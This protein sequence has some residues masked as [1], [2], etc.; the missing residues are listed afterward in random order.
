MPM[1]TS[2]LA[3]LGAFRTELHACFPRRADALFEL[4]DALLCAE[5]FPSLPHLSLEPA[6]RRGWGSVYAALARGRI[7]EDRLRDLL[8]GC[9]PDA[10]PLVFAVDV[11]TWPRCDAE[12]SPERGYYYHPSR[13]SAGQPIIAGWAFQWIAQLSFDRDSWTAPVDAR[14][15]HPLEDT[16]QTAAAQIRALLGRLPAGQA[17]AAVRLRRRLRLRSAHPG[18]GRGAGGGAGA[19]ALRPLLLRRPATSGA[20]AQG[21]PAAPPRGQVRLRRP[22]HLADPER[23]AG[24]PGRPVRHRDRAG[25]GWAASQ[26]SSAIPATAPVGRGRSCAAPSSASRSSASPPAP[27]R[28]RCCGCG[29]PAPAQLDLDLAWRAYVRRFD[30]EHTFR[31]CQAD[32][33]LDHPAPSAPRAGRPLDLA[34]AGRLHPAAPGPRHRRRPAAAV[35]AAPTAATA[36][37]AAGA[38]RVS[39]ASV[40][41]GLASELRRN[42]PGAPQAGPRAAARDLPCVT[43]RSRSQPRDPGAGRPGPQGPPDGPSPILHARRP[44]STVSRHPWVKSQAKRTFRNRSLERLFVLRHCSRLTWLQAG[45]VG[46]GEVPAPWLDRLEERRTDFTAQT[47]IARVNHDGPAMAASLRGD[48]VDKRAAWRWGNVPLPQTYLVGLGAGVLLQMI[49]PW[50]RTL[51]GMGR[52]GLGMA[53]DPRWPLAGGVGG[54]IGCRGGLGTPAPAGPA[55]ALCGQQEPDVPGLGHRTWGSHW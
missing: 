24:L 35:G 38:A 55:R 18:S 45:E 52:P 13:H 37:T 10:D 40:R 26:S 46:G 36:V 11:T 7:D 30:L 32:P 34:G 4:G 51:A 22:D 14:R 21:R 15:L 31:F 5:A 39:A 42:P 3:R 16:D 54:A 8:V 47:S 25:L 20:F 41:T 19:A 33:R 6:H 29:G 1:P 27:A 17:G 49:V 23:Q 53:A 48:H 43:R 9:L 44:R 28:R 2:P 12:C 50:R